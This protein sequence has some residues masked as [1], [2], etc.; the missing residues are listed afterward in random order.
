MDLVCL[1]AMSQQNVDIGIFF[2]PIQMI[3]LYVKS[4][5]HFSLKPLIELHD[6]AMWCDQVGALTRLNVQYEW[7]R[8]KNSTEISCWVIFISSQFRL[9][10][11]ILSVWVI[12]HIRKFKWRVPKS[13]SSHTQY[14]NRHI[15]NNNRNADVSIY[16]NPYV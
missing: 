11:C 12:S 5:E 9:N 2:C 4:L 13:R 15:T 16:N 14:R 8:K 7:N 6:S 10:I 3:E 1:D